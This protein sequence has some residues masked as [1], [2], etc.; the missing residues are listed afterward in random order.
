MPQLLPFF[1]VNQFAAAFVALSVIIFVVA[2]Y[3]LPSFLSL[4]TTRLFF[5]N[6]STPKSSSAS[7]D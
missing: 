6:L 4:Q 3:I 1:F 2:K 5:I 7:K